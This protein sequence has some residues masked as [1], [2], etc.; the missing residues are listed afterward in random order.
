MRFDSKEFQ[1]LKLE[2]YRKLA[3]SGFEDIELPSGSLKEWSQTRVNEEDL[4][5]LEAKGVY[6]GRA[7][8]VLRT[9]PFRTMIDQTLWFYFS[10]GMGCRKISWILAE[11]GIR[12][13]KDKIQKILK[14]LRE[15]TQ[16]EKR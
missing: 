13:N 11:H 6:Y 9:Y 15:E 1:R 10:E 16:F 8:D 7:K 2:W 14:R 4:V 5:R 3:A 12:M